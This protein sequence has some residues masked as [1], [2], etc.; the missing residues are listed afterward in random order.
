M[1]LGQK[2]GKEN[3]ETQRPLVGLTLLSPA[4]GEEPKDSGDTFD[5]LQRLSGAKMAPQQVPTSPLNV[6]KWVWALP[7]ANAK[8]MLGLWMAGA[9]LV[10]ALFFG[11]IDIIMVGMLIFMVYCV[12]GAGQGC[13]DWLAN[14]C[15][16]PRRT[17]KSEG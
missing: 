16:C 10:G 9:P 3:D 7:V 1:A 4:H 2:Q 6:P 8:I 14:G 17:R 12:T 11:F 5:S 15:K 13:S